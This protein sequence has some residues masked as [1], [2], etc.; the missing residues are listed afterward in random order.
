MS[1]LQLGQFPWKS[2]C[3]PDIEKRPMEKPDIT[4]RIFGLS[5]CVQFNQKDFRKCFVV[6]Q[7]TN[8][9]IV[10]FAGCRF[11]CF[12]FYSSLNQEDWVAKLKLVPFQLAETCILHLRSRPPSGSPLFCQGKV[13]LFVYV[14]FC[15]V[16]QSSQGRPPSSTTT[17]S[18]RPSSSSR[19]FEIWL[20]SF[21][22]T[23][24]EF[25][26]VST[27]LWF[28]AQLCLAINGYV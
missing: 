21:V 25:D 8:H 5:N 14:W 27:K 26:F 17:R 9:Q 23:D 18:T 4:W 20:N 1:Q 19:H 16:V 24:P 2:S 11:F 13:S 7:T 15:Y 28:I 10:S 3:F 22:G 12:S 6:C